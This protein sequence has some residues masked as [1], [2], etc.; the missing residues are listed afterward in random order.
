MESLQAR[1]SCMRATCRQSKSGGCCGHREGVLKGSAEDA[2]AG[3]S[4]GGSTEAK[5]DVQGTGHTALQQNEGHVTGREVGRGA[6]QGGGSSA[7]SLG[8]NSSGDVRRSALVAARAPPQLASGMLDCQP[9][10]SEMVQDGVSV[11]ECG[12]GGPYGAV[13]DVQ[14]VC[15]G[16]EGRE[17]DRRVV[18]GGVTR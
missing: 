10:P 3:P 2:G 11:L 7:M 13:V 5:V 18:R 14:D 1:H 15:V 16:R 12:E 17:G 4:L 6:W 8:E 9:P